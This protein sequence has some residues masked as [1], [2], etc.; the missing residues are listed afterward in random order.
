MLLLS[1]DKP[2]TGDRAL[3]D[4]VHV[5]TGLKGSAAWGQVPQGPPEVLSGLAAH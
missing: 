5:D 1:R 3:G 4:L 2:R